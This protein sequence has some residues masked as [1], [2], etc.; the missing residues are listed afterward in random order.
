M[1]KDYKKTKCKECGDEIERVLISPKGHLC[2]PCNKKVRKQ[3]Q[4]KK[5]NKK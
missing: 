1:N 2:V 4:L 3:T 5:Q